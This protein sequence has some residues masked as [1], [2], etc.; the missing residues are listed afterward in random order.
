MAT[1]TDKPVQDITATMLKKLYNG[2]KVKKVHKDPTTKESTQ[3]Y[4]ILLRAG[5]NRPD[6]SDRR[7]ERIRNRTLLDKTLPPSPKQGSTLILFAL[8]APLYI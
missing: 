2:I 3:S 4:S 5:Q 7:E 6:H 1:I 8:T